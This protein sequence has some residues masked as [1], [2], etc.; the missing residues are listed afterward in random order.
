MIKALAL[1]L[2]WCLVPALLPSQYA[3]NHLMETISN[4]TFL[5]FSSRSH[6]VQEMKNDIFLFSRTEVSTLVAMT[7]QFLEHPYVT[8]RVYW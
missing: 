6:F 4:Y 3:R 7:L 8:R 5:L 1:S 2:I